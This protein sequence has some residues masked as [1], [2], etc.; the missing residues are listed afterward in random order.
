MCE[1]HSFPFVS[2]AMLAGDVNLGNER[3]A[4]LAATKKA[5]MRDNVDFET[6]EAIKLKAPAN[7]AI[8]AGDIDFE[9]TDAIKLNA[10]SEV[11]TADIGLSKVVIADNN[12]DV[13]AEDSAQV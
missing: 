10:P 13:G 3:A 6:K 9:T 11:D 4:S 1:Y 8:V 7:A 2:Q 12:P 5:L